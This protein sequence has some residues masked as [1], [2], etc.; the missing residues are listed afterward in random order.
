MYV[1][2]C[3]AVTERQV[4]DEIATGA[5][6]VEAIADRTAASTSCGTCTERIQELLDSAR[7][8]AA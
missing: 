1:C 7:S 2:I 6:S 3:E 5:D 4:R 8:S